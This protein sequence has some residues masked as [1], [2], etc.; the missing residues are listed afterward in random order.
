[1]S[2]WQL[3]RLRRRPRGFVATSLV[4]ITFIRMGGDWATVQRGCQWLLRTRGQESYWL[5]KWRYR[6]FDN[7]VRFDPDKYGWPWTVGAASWVVPTAYSLVALRLAFGCCLPDSARLRLGLG[8][9]MLLAGP[10][11]VAAGTLAMALPSAL[12][13]NRTQT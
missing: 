7:K 4:V 13:W 2:R 3:A 12:H 6:L 8:T 10:A 11:L 9:A 1:M 5:A